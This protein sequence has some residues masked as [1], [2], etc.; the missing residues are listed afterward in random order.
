[1]GLYPT[2]LCVHTHMCKG[3]VHFS[4]EPVH[5]FHQI[6]KKICNP[7]SFKN[8]F[9]WH[10]RALKL[11][12]LMHST[13]ALWPLFSLV[14]IHWELGTGSWLSFSHAEQLCHPV[15]LSVPRKIPKENPV[16]R[17]DPNTNPKLLGWLLLKAIRVMPSFMGNISAWWIQLLLRWFVEGLKIHFKLSFENNVGFYPFPWSAVR[18][19]WSPPVKTEGHESR[20]PWRSILED[21]PNLSSENY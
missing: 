12:T 21:S 1:M 14:N 15:T 17:E 10:L 4:W 19:F 13:L 16:P 18:A 20:R 5:I 11:N 7:K 3:V 9:C 8:H 6:L 2:Q